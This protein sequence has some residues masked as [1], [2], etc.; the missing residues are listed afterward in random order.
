MYFK[1]ICTL[2]CI[3][4]CHELSSN[5]LRLSNKSEDIK[6]CNRPDWYYR[7][8]QKSIQKQEMNNHLIL[9]LWY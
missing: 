4:D 7:K 2:G 8:I 1:N 5:T 6:Y 9:R 3:L